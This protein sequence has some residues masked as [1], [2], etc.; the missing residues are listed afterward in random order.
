MRPLG[1][2]IRE[3]APKGVKVPDGFAV[4]AD[5]YRQYLRENQLDREVANIL[6]GLD[7]AT[8]RTWP[9]GGGSC[10]PRSFRRRCRPT[11]EAAQA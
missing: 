11:D 4:T 1:E 7:T 8:C 2:M 3:L 9:G 5:A 10:A 6:N